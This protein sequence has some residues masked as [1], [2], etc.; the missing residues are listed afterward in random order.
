MPPKPA[1]SL[2]DKARDTFA[3]I[4]R[5]L[6]AEECSL[7]ATTG[8][9][10]WTVSGPHFHSLHKLFDEQRRQLDQWLAQLCQRSA[11]AGVPPPGTLEELKRGAGTEAATALRAEQMIDD[12]LAR[13]EELS[14]KLRENLGALA[15]P[16]T[17]EV[18]QR[19][20]DFHDT[21][22]WMLRMLLEGPDSQRR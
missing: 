20:A 3:R 8:A 15:D 18:V 2:T 7:S 22:A 1:E 5:H 19:L 14:R 12:L 9:Y 16:G 21:T 11:A 17:M 10:R 4:V 13:H 6:L